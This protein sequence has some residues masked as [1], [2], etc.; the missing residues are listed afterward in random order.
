MEKLSETLASVVE[1]ANKFRIAA[2]ILLVMG[3]AERVGTLMDNNNETDFNVK[4]SSSD[5]RVDEIP[6]DILEMVVDDSIN[7]EEFDGWDVGIFLNEDLEDGWNFSKEDQMMEVTKDF[8]CFT[9]IPS[10]NVYTHKFAGTDECVTD[11]ET[12]GEEDYCSSGAIDD[13]FTS[14]FE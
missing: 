4:I 1:S 12:C 14:Y 3:C 13:T 10:M 5:D 8:W 7:A 11:P 9:A 6:Y 2:P